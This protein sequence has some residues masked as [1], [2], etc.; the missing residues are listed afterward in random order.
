MKLHDIYMLTRTPP[1][2]QMY[3]QDRDEHQLASDQKPLIARKPK[4]LGHQSI[5]KYLEK[6]KTEKKCTDRVRQQYR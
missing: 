4:T 2:Y 5:A 1:F 6:T 3:D